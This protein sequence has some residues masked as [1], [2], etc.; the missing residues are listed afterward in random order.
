MQG[1]PMNATKANLGDLL[2]NAQ[3]AALSEALGIQL[4]D[5]R[6]VS[7]L[8]Y[9]KI[10]LLFDPDAD[11]IHSRTLMLLFFHKYLRSVLDE[12][13]IFD[14]HAPQWR[15]EC[16]GLAEPIFARTEVHLSRIKERLRSEGVVEFNVKRFRGLASVGAA[17]LS[18]Q[19][20]DPA[21]RSLH[22]LRAENAQLALQVFQSLRVMGTSFPSSD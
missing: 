6:V 22:Q 5:S 18:R 12:G 1:K 4:S 9:E 11:G 19:C 17:T 7:D 13:R 14:V 20:I 2:K 8:R 16:E 10:I 3:F 21:T 15:I